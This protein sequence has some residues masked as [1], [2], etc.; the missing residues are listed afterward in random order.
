MKNIV[1]LISAVLLV[2]ST[3]AC[4]EEDQ[5]PDIE[6]GAMV[7]FSPGAEDTGLINFLN[8]EASR[9]NFTMDLTD[10]LGRDL[11]FAPVASVDVKVTYTDA[12]TG[13][14]RTT[15]LENTSTWPTTYDLDVQDIVALFPTDVVTVASLELGD[16][17]FITTDFNME[18]GRTL[19]G[20]SPAL[21]DNSPASIYRVFINYPVACP[22][23]LA[24]TYLAECVDCPNGELASQPVT[25]TAVSPGVYSLS[26]VSM[27][28]FGGTPIAYQ[29]SDVCGTFTMAAASQDFGNQVV[30]EAQEGTGVDLETGVVTF[31]LSYVAP[32]CCGL[33]GLGL[34]Y[35]LTPQ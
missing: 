31:N 16:S 29:F 8:L 3:T 27:D 2:V 19:S 11:E 6:Q 13:N 33:A 30:V 20:W 22:S 17:F 7:Y 24:G 5:L 21:L 25:V 18:D 9:L 34:T 1:K 28:I 15:L 26:D 4:Q 12:S 35:T 14:T 32:S 10:A 23:N